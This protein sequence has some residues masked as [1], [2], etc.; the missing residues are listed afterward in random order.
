MV[1][2]PKLE[3]IGF[4]ALG[5]WRD[6]DPRG[7][8]SA[9][10]HSLSL[11][12]E[13]GSLTAAALALGP[14]ADAEAV[15]RFFETHYRP[16]RVAGGP[17]LVTGYYEPVVRGSRVCH[18][19]FQYPVYRTPD[20]L[21]SLTPDLERARFN[22]TMSAGRRVGGALVPYYTRAEIEAG[23]L[24]GKGLELLYLDD[25]IALFY[26]QVQG[27]G[28]VALAEGGEVRLSYA[29]KNGHGYVSIGRLL[30]ERGE[31]DPEAMSMAA[32]KAWL[33]ADETRARALMNENPSYV[34]FRALP[35]TAAGPV[36]ASGAVLTPGRSLAV[37]GALH[38]MGTPVFVTA[39]DLA[40]EMGHPFRRLMI[41]QDVGSAIAGPSRGDIF[42][43]SGEAAGGLAGATRHGCDFIVLLPK[44]EVHV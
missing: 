41:A 17:G 26:M 18:G 21:V 3:P 14:N 36:G 31:I 39:A 44:D 40:D 23:A 30:I 37:D 27:S 42:W 33:K 10:L 19:A 24:A 35:E 1:T 22:A 32:V 15:R 34:F 29:A 2:S 25:A 5:G 4:E 9:L 20:D 16:F 43:G 38:Q 11:G 8:W 13:P 6:D 28:L 12:H 7:A